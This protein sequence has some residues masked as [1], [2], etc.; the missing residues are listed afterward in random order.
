M[1]MGRLVAA[2]I[3]LAV[4]WA[5]R[6]QE[7]P[8]VETPSSEMRCLTVPTEAIEY[9][10]GAARSKLGGL[11]RVKA[12][13]SHPRNAPDVEVTYS[14]VDDP[15]RQQ[16]MERVYR[17]RVPCLA[18]GATFVITQEFEFRPDDAQEFYEGKTREEAGVGSLASCLKGGERPPDY[19]KLSLWNGEQGV[20]MVRYRFEA[21]DAPP[22]ID[23]L[24]DGGRPRLAQAVVDYASGYRL[25]CLTAK[26][27]PLVVSQAFHFRVAGEASRMLRDSRL[28]D[29]L[30]AVD[31]IEKQRVRFD[32]ST[33]GCP[34]DLR[35]RLRQ[36]VLP[37]LVAEIG[38]H[39]VN[40]REFV[41]WMRTLRLKLPDRVLADVMNDSM[42]ITVPCVQL[43]LN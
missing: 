36:P 5:A 1:L 16:V 18:A 13:F 35:L 11:I 31:G 27:F 33:M 34:F 6:A 9:P 19:P 42:I 43:N 22:H 39:D 26:D 14:S 8:S 32:T 25:P 40:R 17:Y 41:E 12:T 21:I 20:V 3:L 23:V 4:A 2:T 37:N 30:A 38:R 7:A 15:F 28:P 10:E 24:F 29:F